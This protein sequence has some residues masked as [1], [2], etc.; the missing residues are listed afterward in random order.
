MSTIKANTLLHSDGTTTTQPSIPALDTR[1]AK[2]WVVFNGTGTVAVIGSYGVSS[3]T[4]L[5]TGQYRVNYTNSLSSTNYAVVVST[6]GAT[7]QYDARPNDLTT[8]SCAI[9]TSNGS[10]AYQDNGRNYVV[11]F[12]N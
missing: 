7:Y 1:M 2:A 6:L 5:G 9:D 8:S 11:I 10:N 4:D 3:M 12:A